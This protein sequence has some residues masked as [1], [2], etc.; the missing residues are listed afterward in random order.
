MGLGSGGLYQW[1]SEITEMGSTGIGELLYRIATLDSFHH[2][3]CL[4][5]QIIYTIVAIK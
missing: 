3:S 1:V 2:Y 4:T 5:T